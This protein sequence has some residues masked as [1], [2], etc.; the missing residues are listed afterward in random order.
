MT[1][2]GWLFNPFTRVERPRALLVGLIVIVASGPA[3]SLGGLHFD[4]LPD[5]TPTYGAPLWLPVGE[6]LVTWL[7]FSGLIGFVAHVLAPRPVR[8][9][10]IAG[11]QALA[12]FPLLVAAL[13]CA[14]PAMRRANADILATVAEGGP[15]V[16]PPAWAF[17]VAAVVGFSCGIWMLWLMWRGFSV[18]CRLRGGRAVV[19]FAAVFVV[20]RFA[21][22]LLV[23]RMLRPH[24]PFPA[25]GG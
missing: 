1:V 7:V 25:P 9:V 11:S 6:G 19:I 23:V 4:G 18:A 14:L 3:A 24:W 22:D 8:F 2:A 20:A 17:L 15:I 16:P 12:R 21:S 13:L 10:D 5:F